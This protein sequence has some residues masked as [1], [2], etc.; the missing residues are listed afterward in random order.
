M[1]EPAAQVGP[2]TPQ[3][4]L[5]MGAHAQVWLATGPT[6]E[7]ALKVARTP[8]ARASLL[9]E[10]EVLSQT[11][12]PHLAELV[13][14]HPKGQ[15]IAL[16]RVAGTTVDQWSRER[17]VGAVVHM[18][19]QLVD[20]LE[21]LHRNDI[22]HGDVKPSNVIMDHHHDAHLID[23][24][25]SCRPGDPVEGFRGTLGYAAP[26]LLSGDPPT[27]STDLYGLGALL[28][29]CLTGR[30]PFVAPDPA[31]LTYLPLISLPAPPSAFRPHLPAILNQLLLA[32]L[33][34]DPQRRPADLDRVRQTLLRCPDGDPSAPILGMLEAREALR[35]AV[36]GAADEEPRVVIIYGA[37]GSGR[38]TLIGEAVEYARREGLPYLRGTDGAEALRSLR[39]AKRPAVLVMR[40]NQKASRQLA[41]RV[42][43]DKLR[44]LLLLHADRPVPKLV[45]AGAVQITPSP[46]SLA[47]AEALAANHG[48]DRE[49]AEEWWRQSM[50]LPIAVLGR[51][52]AWRRERGLTNEREPRLPAESARIYETLRGCPGER[53]AVT[54]LAAALGLAEHALLDHCEVLFAEALVEPTDDGLVL[55]IIRSQGIR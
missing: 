33:A 22:V 24:G 46:L 21:Y 49:Q 50:G 23:L 10:A 5:A 12:H 36:V 11:E 37:P 40:A 25:V 8:D 15:W 43:K 48:A 47:E 42:L 1:S 34:R 55:A 3:Q 27:T 44:C 28:Y 29:S 38:R 6:G 17:D 13:N 9:R 51:I 35:R 7:V 45:A 32:L 41:R 30:T 53:C 2:Y 4:L 20:A 39:D 52:R 31:A 26:E 14:A 54:E 16:K 19:L 18:A